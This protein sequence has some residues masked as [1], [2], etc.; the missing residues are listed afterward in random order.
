[1]CMHMNFKSSRLCS[2]R[3][4]S[5]S[6]GVQLHELLPTHT[7]R[8][9]HPG[10]TQRVSSSPKGPSHPLPKDSPS[11]T[12]STID[13]SGQFSCFTHTDSRG[14]LAAGVQPRSLICTQGEPPRGM[15]VSTFLLCLSATRCSVLRTVYNLPTQNLHL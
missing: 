11:L 8:K 7:P 15:C 2:Y 13:A 12:A 4:T 9:H 5:Q 10:Q 6:V 3:H 14:K 1:M